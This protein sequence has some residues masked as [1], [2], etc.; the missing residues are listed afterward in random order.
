MEKQ[1]IQQFGA[2][3]KTKYP[4]YNDLSD[5]DVGNKVLKKY[6]VYADRVDTKSTSSLP[7][8]QKPAKKGESSFSGNILGIGKKKAQ[9]PEAKKYLDAFNAEH[10]LTSN[11]NPYETEAN[12]SQGQIDALASGKSVPFSSSQ[13]GDFQDQA[14]RSQ[15]MFSNFGSA[16]GITKGI[17]R[18][19]YQQNAQDIQ[20]N[21][22]KVQDFRDQTETINNDAKGGLPGLFNKVPVIGG[23]LNDVIGK[24][25]TGI[26][27]G[28]T[29]AIRGIGAP[30]D[31]TGRTGSEMTA[32]GREAGLSGIANTTSGVVGGYLAKVAPIGTAAF[33]T[34]DRSL[35]ANGMDGVADK[36]GAV[37]GVGGTIGK[38]ITNKAADLAGLSQND[39]SRKYGN[40]AG[41]AFGNAGTMAAAPLIGK[42][43][44]KGLGRL[45]RRNA[46]KLYEPTTRANKSIIGRNS[47][48]IMRDTP[49]AFTKKG[50]LEKIQ[51]S[52]DKI[53][54]KIKDYK[55]D[56]GIKGTVE[57]ADIIKSLEDSMSEN[58]F[59]QKL[60][61]KTIILSEE[62]VKA[63]QKVI[64]TI[65]QFPDKINLADLDKLR[66]TLG[67]QVDQTQKGFALPQDEVSLA[68]QRE[69]LYKEI[70]KSTAKDN[71]LLVPLNDRIS[72]LLDA[73]KVLKETILRKTGQSGIVS[74]AATFGIGS[75]ATTIA[76]FLGIPATALGVG[77]VGT[78]LLRRSPLYNILSAKGKLMVIDAINSK[79]PI[80]KEVLN[81]LKA[82]TQ[83]IFNGKDDEN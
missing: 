53:D 42:A 60:N 73:K 81:A 70:A 13:K 6:P 57:K 46:E 35:R 47:E 34:L 43:V 65:D 26:A 79:R 33:S 19:T 4:Q 17:A 61:G 64:Q 71:P 63:T 74:K 20:A 66:Q 54:Q 50:V 12:V 37:L 7:T 36:I 28:L 82:G 31:A 18:K 25:A 23:V 39:L 8:I 55:K 27:G 11:L 77:V 52:A 3:I 69:A 32:P 21:Q 9:D 51:K 22:K 48:T 72:H 44:N 62:G 49:V 2:S 45:I 38:A 68:G 16:L 59:T 76:G 41:T 56:V 80:P 24:P 78:I 58:G 29:N 67:K 5:E 75:F 30:I 40:E 10:G 15:G 14:T 83:P 1:T